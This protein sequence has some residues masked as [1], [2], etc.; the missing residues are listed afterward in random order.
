MQSN[1]YSRHHLC[2]E[3]VSITNLSSSSLKTLGGNLEEIGE[4]S[5]LIVT[6]EAVPKGTKIRIKG[7]TNELEGSVRSC[8]FDGLLGYSV[9]IRLDAGSR[10]SEEWF[11]PEHLL[12]L[13]PSM[14]YFTEKTPKVPEKFILAKS[15]HRNI[16]TAK[17]TGPTIQSTRRLRACDG[18][19]ST[20]RVRPLRAHR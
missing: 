20:P 1:T 16:R 5:A 9:D 12:T 11:R 3:L 4:W 14:R 15:A 2:S 13:C 7:Q 6:E 18:R 8:R 17:R 19:W 10:W